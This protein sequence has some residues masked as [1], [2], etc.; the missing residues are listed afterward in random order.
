MY[1]YYFLTGPIHI[2]RVM[3]KEPASSID[4]ISPISKLYT[5]QWINTTSCN[6]KYTLNYW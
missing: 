4:D 6:K 5:D 2:L 3:T 1:H